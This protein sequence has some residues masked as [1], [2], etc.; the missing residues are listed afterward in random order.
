MDVPTVLATVTADCRRTRL[1]GRW[2]T[3][4]RPPGHPAICGCPAP[5]PKPEAEQP[6]LIRTAL[7]VETRG[8]TRRPP[9]LTVASAADGEPAAHRLSRGGRTGAATSRRAQRRPRHEWR[10]RQSTPAAR[11][12]YRRHRAVGDIR[13][14]DPRPP[15]PHPLTLP[16]PFYCWGRRCRERPSGSSRRGQRW[17]VRARVACTS[18]S[19]AASSSDGGVMSSRQQGGLVRALSGPA[20]MPAAV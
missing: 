16:A 5:Q 2:S 3:G 10:E 18:L 6:P 15:P 13:C 1:A 4:S 11:T 17:R 9:P 8:T 19:T 20:V 7:A 14:D 12:A